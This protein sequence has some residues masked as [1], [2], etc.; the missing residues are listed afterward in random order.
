[1][2]QRGFGIQTIATTGV[3]VPLFGTTLTA[4]ATPSPDRNTGNTGVA[5]Q[6]SSTV[7]P[8]AANI[9]RTGD[10]VQLGTAPQFEQG[11]TVIP[12]G[13]TVVA[14]NIA[15]STITVMGLTRAHASG[16]FVVLALP[17][18]EVTVYGVGSAA[19]IYFGEDPTVGVASVTLFAEL[20][21]AQA[22]AGT[23]WKY[24]SGVGLNA[25]ETQHIWISGTSGNEYLP[26]FLTV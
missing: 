19:T 3:G 25:I 7:L 17:C 15:G 11:S 26:S 22:T 18:A 20:I 2:S 16:E 21:A 1:M 8:V 9:F 24:G 14:I 23:P 6:P 12:D 10:H 13:G 5:S 4:A